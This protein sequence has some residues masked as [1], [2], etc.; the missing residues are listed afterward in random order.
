MG[1]ERV[2]VAMLNIREAVI[3]SIPF[4]QSGCL[5]AEWPP[6]VCFLLCERSCMMPMLVCVHVCLCAFLECMWQSIVKGGLLGLS[7]PACIERPLFQLFRLLPR[8]LLKVVQ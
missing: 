8:R 3:I 6:F 7:K 4:V 1:T 5:S 2:P